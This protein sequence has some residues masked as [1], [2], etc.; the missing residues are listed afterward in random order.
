MTFSTILIF[1]G[2]H[3]IAFVGAAEKAARAPKRPLR[4]CDVRPR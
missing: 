1:A 4:R 2:T 3:A